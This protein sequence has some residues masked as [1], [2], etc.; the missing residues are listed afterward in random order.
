MGIDDSLWL[1]R[2]LKKLHNIRV[3]S[4]YFMKRGDNEVKFDQTL[5]TLFNYVIFNTTS[6]F[7]LT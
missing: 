5:Y 7:L 3:S 4:S 1:T 2:V 6:I